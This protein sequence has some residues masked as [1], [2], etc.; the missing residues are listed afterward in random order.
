MGEAPY[1]LV[2]LILASMKELNQ[3][4]NK[5]TMAGAGALF[6]LA[7]T[8]CGAGNGTTMDDANHDMTTHNVGKGH[9]LQNGSGTDSGTMLLTR[10]SKMQVSQQIADRIASLDE[11]DSASVLLAGRTAYVAVVMPSGQGKGSGAGVNGGNAGGSHTLSMDDAPMQIKERIASQVRMINPNIRRVYI[12]ANPDF[13]ARMNGFAQDVMSGRPVSGFMDEFNTLVQRIF[14]TNAGH[15]L[16]SQ[17][18]P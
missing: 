3:L 12:S 7:L 10:D 2:N 5:W 6:A 11:V 13:V 15:A 17:P 8:G 4:L 18:S 14:P 9:A 16:P 1:I